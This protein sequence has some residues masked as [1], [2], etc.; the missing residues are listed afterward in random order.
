MYFCALPEI[1]CNQA[2]INGWII[3]ATIKMMSKHEDWYEDGLSFKCTQCGNCCSGP[4]GYV[5]FT[6]DEEAQMAE[7][8]GVD[9]K[10]FRKRYAR[11][12]MGRWTLDEVKKNGKYDCIFL[13]RDGQGKAKCSI[14]PVRPAQCRTWPFW[15]ENL[16]SAKA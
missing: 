14:Y 13:K 10:E 7:Y 6:G 16:T 9:I 12:Q 4:P 15:P 1:L 3:K 2:L 5:W 8:L 11:N